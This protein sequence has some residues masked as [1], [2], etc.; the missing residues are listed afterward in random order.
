M[1]ANFTNFE[2]AI[3]A[4]ANEALNTQKQLFEC[5]DSKRVELLAI[6]KDLIDCQAD[7][8]K[9]GDMM[10]DL[11]GVLIGMNE[12]CVRVA[13]KIGGALDFGY[14]QVPTCS[15][16]SYVDT[17]EI[18]GLDITHEQ[19][20]TEGENGLVHCHCLNSVAEVEETVESN[21]E[22]VFEKD[23]LPTT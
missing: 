17:C 9:F 1:R 2:N 19:E 14:D 3:Q 8:T 21:E 15:F 20:Y 4:F 11:A 12:T 7:I 5:A 22:E 6:Y 16:E 10:N 13:D 18:C 23:E